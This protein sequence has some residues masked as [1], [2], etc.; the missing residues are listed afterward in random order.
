MPYIRPENSFASATTSAIN[1]VGGDM[2]ASVCGVSYSRLRQCANPMR[3]DVIS[4]QAAFDADIAAAKAGAG[5]PHFEVYAA[6]LHDAGAITGFAD[7]RAGLRALIKSI[8]A[9]LREC[10]DRMTAAIEPKPSLC[11]V[12]V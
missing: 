4:L 6:R 8:A 3:S 5:C 7:E 1:A 12:V 2:L 10:A 11:G 9:L